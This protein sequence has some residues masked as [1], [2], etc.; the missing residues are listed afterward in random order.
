MP[1]PTTVI[2]TLARK[3]REHRKARG[4]S[5]HDLARLASISRGPIAYL[6]TEASLPSLETLLAIARALRVP[7]SELLGET[8]ASPARRR[9]AA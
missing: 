4:L 6:E 7:V 1:A 5:Q 8:P 3:V 9:R 2:N